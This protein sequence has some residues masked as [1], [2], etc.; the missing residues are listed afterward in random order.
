MWSLAQPSVKVS[1]F[2]RPC[3]VE[4]SVHLDGVLTGEEGG[5]FVVAGGLCG[6]T[7]P[8]RK[9]TSLGKEQRESSRVC[10]LYSGMVV[11]FP[12]PSTIYPLLFCCCLYLVASYK[13]IALLKFL[14]LLS[15]I[16]EN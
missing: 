14:T 10:R 4:K 15:C 12:L 16:A 13:I 2:E 8:Q 1:C 9:H 7:P 3:L 5:A 11:S 6:T